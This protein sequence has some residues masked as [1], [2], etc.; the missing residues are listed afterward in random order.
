MSDI[1]EYAPLLLQ[2]TILTI[3][4]S[5]ISVALSV[6]IGILGALAKLSSNP[7]FRLPASLYSTVTRGIPDLVLML[8]IFYGGQMLVND[9]AYAVGYEEYIDI[10]SFVAGVITIGFIFGAYMTETFR[11]AIL[12]VPKGQ[13]EGAM[14]L[15]LSKRTTFFSIILPQ[16][17]LHALPSF[18][19]N[20]LILMKTTA[21]V[22]LIGL[23]D[24]VRRGGEAGSATHQPFTFYFIVSLIYLLLTY[25]SQVGLD[26]IKQRYTY[27]IR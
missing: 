15:G 24:L 1:I 20:W 3:E 2:G 26:W 4:L 19:N 18:T 25:F 16:M 21:L 22:S 7:F 14:A 9:L 17:M 23:Q 13:F 5:L 11:G 12:A 8:L 6:F 10:N 27:P